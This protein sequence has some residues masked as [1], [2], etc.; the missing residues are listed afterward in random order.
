MYIANHLQYIKNGGIKM[1]IKLKEMRVKKGLS[2]EQLGYI[3]KSSAGT[4]NRLEQ[5]KVKS[6][7]TALLIAKELDSTV[8][9][10]FD[11]KE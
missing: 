3:T 10:I 7:Q 9:E 1:S 5:Q 6:I 4:I 8:E 2:R 11:Y